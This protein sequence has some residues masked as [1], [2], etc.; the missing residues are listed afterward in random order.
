[1]QSQT[2]N[3]R[4]KILMAFENLIFENNGKV[5]SNIEIAKKAGVAKGAMYYYFEDKDKLIDAVILSTVDRMTKNCIKIL[6]NSQL[7][8]LQKLSTLFIFYLHNLRTNVFLGSSDNNSF[9]QKVI[10]SYITHL[11]PVLTNIIEEGCSS[12]TFSCK[13][14]ALIAEFLLSELFITLDPSMIHFTHEELEQKMVGLAYV[15]SKLLETNQNS[16][17]FLF[18]NL[19]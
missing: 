3:T 12:G 11:T 17:D 15:M 4:E 18:K 13:Y 9:H 14:P 19:S 1:M 2:M 5:P 16:F 7:D 10:K 6:S 8:S